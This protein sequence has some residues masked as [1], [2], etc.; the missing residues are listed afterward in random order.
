[1]HT[2][3]VKDTYKIN[4][5]KYLLTT[6]Q[7]AKLSLI[8]LDPKNKNKYVTVDNKKLYIRD[9]SKLKLS[10]EHK[11]EYKVKLIPQ[12]IDWDN[13]NRIYTGTSTPPKLKQLVCKCSDTKTIDLV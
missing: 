10:N 6:E 1:M 12:R 5:V 9:I 7:W 2:K 13:S 3:Q 4:N 11:H 8:S